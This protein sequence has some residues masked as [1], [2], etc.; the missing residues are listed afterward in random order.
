MTWEIDTWLM[1]CRVLGRRVEEAVLLD[2]VSN[3]KQSGAIK[4]VG[5]YRP[6][7]RNMIVKNHY[8][9]LGFTK[10]S[11]DD[12]SETWAL[13]IAQYH[14]PELPISFKYAI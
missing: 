10:I 11:S 9:K 2:I 5:T 3:A 13:D 8:S 6:T 4:L 1:S 12:R 7:A 14:P